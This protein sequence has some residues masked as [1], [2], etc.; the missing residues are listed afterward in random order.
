MSSS[1]KFNIFVFSKTVGY[2]HD[3]I[4]AG[5]EGLKN[6][7]TS[8]NSFSVTASEDSCLINAN[9]LSRFKVVVFLSTSGEFL[10]GEE[11][12]GLKTFVNNGGGF[13]GIHCAAAGM[14]EEPWYG[15]LVGAYFADHP[16]P[17]HGVVKV[18]NKDHVI[19][20]EFPEEVKWFDEWYNFKSNPRGKVTVLLSTDES[21]YQ[22]GTMGCDHPL[23][24]CREFDGGRAFYT[25]LG[26]FDEAYR[27]RT[28]ITHLLNGILWA[29]HVV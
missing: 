2:R 13:V 21:L 20:S 19:M 25:A 28:F 1:D 5:I 4:P 23:A 14:Y 27:D 3:S 22:G 8:T 26:H 18:E 11:L 24:W 15:E 6:L 17:Q 9:F 16:E 29:A 12:Q 10:T 7:G